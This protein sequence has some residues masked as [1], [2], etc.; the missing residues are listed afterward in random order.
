MAGMA[1][2]SRAAGPCEICGKP[3]SGTGYRYTHAGS[4]LLEKTTS[5]MK[6]CWSCRKRGCDRC[7]VLVEERADDH[8]IEIASCYSCLGTL[9][10]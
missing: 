4:R 3:A 10:A 9:D 1:E 7:L 6:R 5:E 8:F 2:R